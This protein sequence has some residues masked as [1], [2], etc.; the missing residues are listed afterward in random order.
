MGPPHTLTPR[1]P[2]HTGAGVRIAIIGPPR[3]GK[4][5][6]G[7]QLARTMDCA[8]LH[9]DDLMPLGWSA[10]SAECARVLH[11]TSDIIVE[12]VAVVRALRK[13]LAACACKPCER[14]IILER[15]LERLTRGQVAMSRGCATVL[16]EIEAELV[17]RGVLMER[18]A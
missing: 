16:R 4:T 5:T 6:L 2:T 8:I 3:A 11:A 7:D 1:R 15:P 18:P 9:T 13:C 12:G 17:R 14:C 10:A